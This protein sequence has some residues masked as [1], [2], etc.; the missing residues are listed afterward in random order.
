[1]VNEINIV[2]ISKTNEPKS[3]MHFRP[4]GLCN[5]SYKTIAKV[6]VNRLKYVLHHCI[7]DCQSA[8]VPRRL[9]MDNILVAYEL[10][11]T[12]NAK[13]RHAGDGGGQARYEQSL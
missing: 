8:F 7:G 5:I 4:I 6:I 12:L 9:I 13:K 3:M 2:L 10:I 11:H 1:M